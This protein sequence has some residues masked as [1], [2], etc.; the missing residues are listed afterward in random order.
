MLHLLLLQG[1]CGCH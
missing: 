1:R